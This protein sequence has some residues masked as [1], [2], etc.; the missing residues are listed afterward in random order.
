[1][2][3]KNLEELKNIKTELREKLKS[4][5]VKICQYSKDIKVKDLIQN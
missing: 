4:Y 5:L 2:R 1:L 3:N